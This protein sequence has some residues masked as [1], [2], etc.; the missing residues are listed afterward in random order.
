[1]GQVP[2]TFGQAAEQGL[3]PAG[4]GDKH[5]GARPGT[6]RKWAHRYWLEPHG[7]IRHHG[8]LV[9]AYALRDILEI[10]RQ[11]R[12]AEHPGG[13]LIPVKRGR[14]SSSPSG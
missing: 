5:L 1:M 4:V 13:E 14:S 6:V 2:L 9:P 7:L 10:D 8:R 11:T 3:V 12:L